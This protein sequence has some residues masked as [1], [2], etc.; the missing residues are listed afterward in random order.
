MDFIDIHTH[1]Q[2][3]TGKSILNLFPSDP[4]PENSERLYSI[5]LHP[6]YIDPSDWKDKTEIVRYRAKLDSCISIGETGIDK[7]AESNYSLQKKIFEKHV[8][9]AEEMNKPLIVH[10]V[11]AF[12]DLIRIKRSIGVGVPW[13]VHGFNSSMKI[14]DRLLNEGIMVSFGRS[15]GRSDSN[16]QKI[17]GIISETQFFLETD[18][19]ILCIEE[20][21]SI[22]AELRKIQIHTLKELI[23]RNYEH[24]FT[25]TNE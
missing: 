22:V 19:G 12:D 4:L 13:I 2:T 11:R 23:Q 3:A 6:W 25:L 7:L 14:A 17:S 18:D 20:I 24:T 21:Y 9:I 10:C 5:G 15:L 16:A 8:E 1:H